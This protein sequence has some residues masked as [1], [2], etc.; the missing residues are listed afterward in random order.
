MKLVKMLVKALAVAVALLVSFRYMAGFS[1]KQSIVLTV[2]AVAGWEFCVYVQ[3]TRHA[4][5]TFRPFYVRVIPN[6]YELLRDYN[7][8]RD[9]QAWLELKAKLER[10]PASEYIVLRNG[11][12][13]TVLNAEPHSFWPSLIYSNNHGNFG[14]KVDFCEAIDRIGGPEVCIKWGVHGYEIGITV[15]NIEPGG[16]EPRKWLVIAA[17]PIEEFCLYWYETEFLVQHWQEF[18]KRRDELLEENGWKRKDVSIPEIHVDWPD[19]IEH[20]YFTV[21]HKSI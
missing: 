20:R 16:I 12:T 1:L 13:F 10:A 17:L 5:P 19:H 8:I 2:L 15:S 18:K 11:I 14:T 9:D 3:A 7:L 6:W 21:E 4:E